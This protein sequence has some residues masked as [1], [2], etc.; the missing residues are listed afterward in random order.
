MRPTLLL[1]AAVA[2][3]AVVCWF[4]PCGAAAS[5]T[6]QPT[7]VTINIMGAPARDAVRYIS[8]VAGL[9]LS[10]LWQDAD[11]EEGL[12]PDGTIDLGCTAATPSE[13]LERLVK[14]LGPG[15]TWQTDEQ[16]S[17]EIG[18]R[19]RL[20]EHARVVIYDVKDLLTE[21]PDYTD[22]PSI[23]LQGALQAGSHSVF[24]EE[25]SSSTKARHDRQERAEELINLISDTVE[26]DE[27]VRNGGRAATIRIYQDSLIVRAPGYIHRQI[28]G[29][30]DAAARARR[31]GR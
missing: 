4:V 3:P 20:N 17:I 18:P 29:S 14:A 27:W 9:D 16:G 23:D 15:V 25:P 11:H 1:R 2:I 22:V 24:R 8:T 28:A 21:T 31:A 30:I 5:P 26:P 13:V 12:D 6:P 10:P 7:L 19:S